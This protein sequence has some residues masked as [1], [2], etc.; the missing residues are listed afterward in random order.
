LAIGVLSYVL[1]AN[2]SPSQG[3]GLSDVWQRHVIELQPIDG[4]FLLLAALL[5]TLGMSSTLVRWYILVR[6][7]N[8]PFTLFQAIRIGTLS[9]LCNAF[10]PGS[11]GGDVIKAAAL[12]RTQDRRIVAVATVVMDRALSIWAL[13]LLV[14]VVG[15]IAWAFD[16]LDEAALG[17]SETIIVTADMLIGISLALWIVTGIWSQRSTDQLSEKLLRVPRIGESLAHLWQAAWLYRNRPGAI[18]SAIALSTLSNICDILV[19]YAYVRTLW[20]GL[21]TNPLPGFAEHFLLVPVGLVVSGVPLFPGGT[22]IGEAGFG[23]LY[24]L[25]GSASSNGVLGSLLFRISS[26]IV[27]IVGYL[28]C[29]W[30]DRKKI[31]QASAF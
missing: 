28:G 17:P 6:A 10:L 3:G 5:D 9:F 15:T 27:G 4:K 26:W 23:G 13:V 11:V 22:G 21:S 19:F 1:Y 8:L 2:W 12:A 16:L 18:A 14:A 24:R 20:D 30:L 7:Q 25:F 31:E 29:L